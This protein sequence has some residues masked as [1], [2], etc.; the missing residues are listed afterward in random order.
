MALFGNY[1]NKYHNLT[2]MEDQLNTVL[3]NERNDMNEQVG[4]I[5]FS[6]TA[7]KNPLKLTNF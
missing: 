5:I 2:E 1:I 3:I 4:L 7:D 6:C